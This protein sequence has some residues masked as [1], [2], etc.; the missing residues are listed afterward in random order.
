MAVSVRE[1]RVPDD[2][3]IR[4]CIVEL[5]EFERGIEPRLRAGESMADAY[6]G[7]IQQRCLEA[8]GRTFV[9]E[10]GGLVV[11]FVAVVAEQP[12]EEL[13][14]PPGTYALV[15]DLV[16][17]PPHRGRGIGRLLLEHAEDFVRRAGATELRIG[18]LAKNSTARQLYLGMGFEPTVEILSKRW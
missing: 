18:V 9:A 8:K 15:T 1:C 17:L 7:R 3:A 13:D 11:G 4:R 14:D 16:V 6:W 5:Q 2:E 10:D 12:F